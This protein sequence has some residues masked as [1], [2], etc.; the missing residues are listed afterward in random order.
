MLE[1]I[2]ESACGSG[3]T[4]V[5]TPLLL[6]QD[7]TPAFALDFMLKDLNLAKKKVLTPQ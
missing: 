2:N 5:K 3:A 6:Q 7:Y 4:K 1:I